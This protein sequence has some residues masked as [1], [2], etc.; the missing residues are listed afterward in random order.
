VQA[1][2]E[3][4]EEIKMLVDDPGLLDENGEIHDMLALTTD[5]QVQVRLLVHTYIQPL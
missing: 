2:Q 5:L 1:F 4:V 3:S